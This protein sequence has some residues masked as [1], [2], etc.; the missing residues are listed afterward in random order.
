MTTCRPAT[1]PSK[2]IFDSVPGVVILI[3]LQFADRGAIIA[4]R[5]RAMVAIGLMFRPLR[6]WSAGHGRPTHDWFAILLKRQLGAIE[7]QRIV[8]V[9]PVFISAQSIPKFGF[10]TP[11]F[12]HVSPLLSCLD[13]RRQVAR[14]SAWPSIRPDAACGGYLVERS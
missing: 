13:L 9:H 2:V 1:V 4:L 5:Q 7:C 12:G 14:H 6:P 11:G 3:A 10:R 8:R